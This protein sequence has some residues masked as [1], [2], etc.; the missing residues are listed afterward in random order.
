[1]SNLKI[2]FA[3]LD[4]TPPLGVPMAGYFFERLAEGVLDPLYLNAVAFSDGEN[5]AVVMTCDLEGIASVTMD[6]WLPQI[7]ETVGLPKEALFIAC[8]HTHT[9]PHLPGSTISGSD[10][11]YDGWFLRRMCDTCPTPPL[12][13]GLR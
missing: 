4:M 10:E 8:T 11:Q 5:T 3:R 6:K 7:A 13:A 1:M 2:G 12:S 9:G